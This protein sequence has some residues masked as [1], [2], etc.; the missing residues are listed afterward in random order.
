MPE[1]TFKIT[2][3]LGVLSESKSG[4]KKEVNLVVWMDNPEKVD[5]RDWSPDHSKMGK[6]VTFTKDEV[7]NLISILKEYA[8]K[9]SI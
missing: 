1:I 4:W 5:I 7:K 3:H 2:N 8:K 9:V 6:G